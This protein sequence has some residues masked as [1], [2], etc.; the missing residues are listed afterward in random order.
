ME[1]L[2]SR[3]FH[4]KAG[5]PNNVGLAMQSPQAVSIDTSSPFSLDTFPTGGVFTRS[6]TF[7]VIIPAAAGELLLIPNV[8]FTNGSATIR[9]SDL[10]RFSDLPLG[11][12][13]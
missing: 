4:Y 2:F 9:A 6:G 10:V 8:Q 5:S 7:M 13:F 11:S 3:N 1:M 12:E